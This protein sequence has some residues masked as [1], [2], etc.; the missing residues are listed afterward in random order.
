ML[1][2]LSFYG[3]L[4]VIF[5]VIRVKLT[6]R[7][8][9]VIGEGRR[10]VRR[11][12]L[13]RGAAREQLEE[14]GGERVCVTERALSHSRTLSHLVDALRVARVVEELVSEAVEGDDEEGRGAFASRRERNTFF[15][16]A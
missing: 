1:V 11:A 6:S 8:G 15:F 4:S 5:M 14:R 7:D 2:G 12:H 10:R 16:H 3:R 9:V 13:R